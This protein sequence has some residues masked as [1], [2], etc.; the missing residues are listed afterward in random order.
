MQNHTGVK[1]LL[2][3]RNVLTNVCVCIRFWTFLG[4][5]HCA[6]AVSRETTGDLH[7]PFSHKVTMVPVFW[8]EIVLNYTHC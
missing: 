6:F 5:F 3:Q 1:V 8:K 7:H 2:Q 4:V